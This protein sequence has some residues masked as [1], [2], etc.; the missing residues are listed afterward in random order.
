[1][2]FYTSE[3]YLE[4]QLRKIKD[5][6]PENYQLIEDFV[7]DLLAEGISPKRVYTYIFWLRKIIETADTKLDNWGRREVRKVINRYQIECNKGNIS[8][9]SLREVKKTLK[10]FF[11]WLGREDLVNWF[12]LGNVAPKISPQDLITTEEFEAMLRTCMNSRC[13]IPKLFHNPKPNSCEKTNE[14]KDQVDHQT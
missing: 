12:S 6:H 9:N 1:M 4:S 3:R 14:Q 10:K 7:E 2:S 11:K 8:E 13:S 5:S